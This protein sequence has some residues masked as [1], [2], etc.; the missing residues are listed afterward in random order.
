MS[1][2][3]Y[4]APSITIQ[5][6]APNNPQGDIMDNERKNINPEG[7]FFLTFPSFFQE[8]LSKPSFPGR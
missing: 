8:A 7:C 1:F 3:L 2:S 6:P 4:P 5:T